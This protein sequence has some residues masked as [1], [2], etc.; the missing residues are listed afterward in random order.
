MQQDVVNSH[1]LGYT[2]GRLSDGFLASSLLV[3]SP[4]FVFVVAAAVAVAAAE[5]VSGLCRVVPLLS[6][7]R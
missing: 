5:V 1:H 6:P 4:C 7:D 2:T 3:L